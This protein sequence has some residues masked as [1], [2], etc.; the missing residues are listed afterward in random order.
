M[1]LLKGSWPFLEKSSWE[2]KYEAVASEGKPEGISLRNLTTGQG[3]KR[4][5][6]AEH[7]W[8]PS[9]LREM[10]AFLS[11]MVTSNT[12]GSKSQQLTPTMSSKG[13]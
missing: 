12:E 13:A 3:G 1:E 9:S 2:G 8:F 7:L 6:E 4:G 10:G 5:R 11:S